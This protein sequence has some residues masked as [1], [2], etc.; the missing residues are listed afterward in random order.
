MEQYLM[1]QSLLSSWAYTFNAADGYEDAAMAD[2]LATLRREQKE[3][4]EAMRNGINFE[5]LVYEIASGKFKAEW[6]PTG[7][8][9]VNS[10]EPIGKYPKE[11]EGASKVA[12][13]IKGG[14]IQVKASR[15]LEAA[16]M[17]FLVYGIL[18]ALKAG[19]IYDVKFLNKSMG[20][21]ELAGKYLESAQHPAYFYIIPEAH[22]FQY[23]V[24]DGKDLYI[25][26][27]FRAQ[28][29]PI[30]EIVEEFIRSIESMGLL[31]VYKTFWRAL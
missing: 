24:S 22:E 17:N 1:T 23:L 29:R 25:E 26:Q 8:I 10:G 27:Y 21:A 3:P 30:S 19:T 9:E 5:N 6:E 18:D 12:E 14:V 16:G 4:S 20:S 11:Y 31:E 13:I 2:F 15:V 7:E 28:A